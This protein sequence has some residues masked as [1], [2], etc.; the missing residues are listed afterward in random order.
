MSFSRPI[1]WYHSNADP[2]WADCTF[3]FIFLLTI[4]LLKSKMVECQA[5]AAHGAGGLEP[6]PGD[7]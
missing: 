1:Q 2:I 3:N 6:S 5:P 7:H 4:D